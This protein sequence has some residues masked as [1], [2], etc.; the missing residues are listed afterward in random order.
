MKAI[1]TFSSH[2]YERYAKHLLETFVKTWPCDLVV[3]YEKEPPDFSHAK[4]QYRPL[5]ELENRKAFFSISELI[6]GS[7]GTAKGDYS[8]TWDARKFCNKVFAQLAVEDDYTFWLDADVVCHE[9]IS[10]DYLLGLVEDTCVTYFGRE[11]TY[12]ETGFLGFNQTHPDWPKFKAQY[13]AVYLTGNIFKQPGWHDCYALKVALKDIA[14]RNLSPMGRGY[15]DVIGSS[16]LSQYL[17]H[18]KGQRKYRPFVSRDAE[19]RVNPGK[20][21][22]SEFFLRR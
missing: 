17:E 4:V 20:T 3:F 1:T 9:P 13:E 15:E 18:R 6:P 12:P 22:V 7:N 14:Q 19:R 8:Y 16:E 21:S 2:G 11:G 10:K 5:R